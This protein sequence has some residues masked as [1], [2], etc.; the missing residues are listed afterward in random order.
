[1]RP[2]S[3]AKLVIVGGTYRAATI[4]IERGPDAKICEIGS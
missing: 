3:V 4:M 1:L 2:Q